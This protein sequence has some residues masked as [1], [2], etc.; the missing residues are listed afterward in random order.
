MN[1]RVHL[2]SIPTLQLPERLEGF[3]DVESDTPENAKV[4]AL[5]VIRVTGRPKHSSRHWVIEKVETRRAKS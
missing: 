1:F 4:K 3:R 2:R 5:R